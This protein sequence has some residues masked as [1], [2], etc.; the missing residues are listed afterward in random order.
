MEFRQLRYFLAVAQTLHF[1]KAAELMG[2]AQPPLSQQIQK[3]ER[4]I[5]TRLFIRH[6]RHVELTEAGLFFKERAQKI[7]AETDRALS[8]IKK[9]ARG[10][11]GRLSV[12]FAGSTV[13][14]SLIAAAMQTYRRAFPEVVIHSTESNSTALLSKVQDAELDCAIVRLPLQVGDLC[15]QPIVAEPMIAVLPSEHACARQETIDLAL[16]AADDF[17]AFPRD[18]G[19]QL[20]DS[21]LF[22]CHQAGFSPRISMESPQISSSINLVAAGFGVAIIPA[23]LTSIRVDGVSFHPLQ[24]PLTTG[25][26]LI[27]RSHEKS[28]LTQHFIKTVRD[29]GQV[30]R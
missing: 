22:A 25:L 4:E 10:E 23:S 27:Y 16:L 18:I 28:A 11:S 19:P 7:L 24:Q 29:A 26:G 1:T 9:V 20:Y 8:E 17:I 21:I 14:H 13:F 15:C 30:A 12:G 6:Q 2:I 3:L 5:G